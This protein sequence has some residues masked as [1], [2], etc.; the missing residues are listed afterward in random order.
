MATLAGLLR[1]PRKLYWGWYVVLV[2]AAAHFVSGGIYG[3]GFG[4]FFKPM[5]QDLGL[6]RTMVAGATSLRSLTNAFTGPLIGPLLDKYGPRP[7]MIV[8]SFMAVLGTMAMGQVRDAF[9]FYLIMGVLSPL[10]MAGIGDLVAGTTVAKWFIRYRGR[11]LGFSAAGISAG[12]A[13]IAP[14]NEWV[15]REYD[16][17]TA[18]LVSALLV[19]AL[20]MLPTVLFMRRSPESMGLLPDGDEAPTEAEPG[21]HGGRAALREQNWSLREAVRT[22][23]LWLTI[24]AL[25]LAGMGV[26]GITIHQVPYVTDLGYS[27]AIA[28]SMITVWGVFALLAKVIFGFLGEKYTVRYLTAFCFFGSAL[29]VLIIMQADRGI[30][31]V[32]AY[33]VVHGLLRGGYPLLV[34]LTWA[35]YYGRTFLGTIRGIVAPFSLISSAMGPV[36]AGWLFDQTGSYTL[37]FGMFIVALTLGGLLMLV[38]KPPAHKATPSGREPLRTAAG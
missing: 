16:W 27:P 15:I 11:A 14:I 6:T 37:A 34:P 22:P 32:Y 12:I 5:A 36:F 29:G 24:A 10:A 23:T 28:A 38:A 30:F 20:V 4:V 19:G 3:T 1:R 35:N 18:W 25:D 13:V 26:S 33:A 31:F 8:G 9:Q 17:R 7:I 21:F 2:S